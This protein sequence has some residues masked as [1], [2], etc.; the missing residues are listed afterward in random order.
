MNR[1]MLFVERLSDM[2][3]RL[4]LCRLPRTRVTASRLEDRHD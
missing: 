2:G 4:E 1:W 3:W